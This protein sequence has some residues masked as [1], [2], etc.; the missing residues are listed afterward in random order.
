MRKEKQTSARRAR[1]GR[2][3]RAS[4]FGAAA[5]GASGCLARNGRARLTPPPAQT[6]HGS[7]GDDDEDVVVGET[8]LEVAPR[9]DL[10]PVSDSARHELGM[11]SGEPVHHH[12]RAASPGADVFPRLGD[13]ATPSPRAPEMRAA[14]GPPAP[15]EALPGG[16]PH[17]DTQAV[18]PGAGAGGGTRYQTLPEVTLSPEVERKIARIAEAY[19]RRTGKDLVLTS[20]TR[21][22]ARQAEAMYELLR[23]GTDLSRLY[24]NRGAAR[25]LSDV[26]RA[27]HAARRGAKQVIAEL[28]RVLSAQ[29]ARGTYVS[30]HL[31]AGAV[32][33]R[34]RGMS[35]ADKRAF[36]AGV[37]E[38]GGA[39]VIE[40][41]E[42]PHFHLELE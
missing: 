8:D 4:L 25:E 29:V 33:V 16:P 1:L 28:E 26:F 5:L 20:G 27:A 19:H 31:R 15:A 39:E 40:E 10:P 34:S 17:G 2:V 37:E 14:A 21:D 36:V 3:V 35:V 23:L 7:R 32:D 18:A 24:R 22:V 12:A 9:V 6:Q 42:P 38:V 11:I 41:L 30:A 13:A